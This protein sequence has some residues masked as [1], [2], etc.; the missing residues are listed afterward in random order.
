[1]SSEEYLLMTEILKKIEDR[2]KLVTEK[3][4]ELKMKI[5]HSIK[6]TKKYKSIEELKISLI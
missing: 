3:Q 6:E 2:F 4:A 5:E 1:M